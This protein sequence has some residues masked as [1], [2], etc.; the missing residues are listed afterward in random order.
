[1]HTGS[2]VTQDLLAAWASARSLSRGLP[3]AVIDGEAVRVDTALPSEE[4]R[5]I[6]AASTPTISALAATIDRPGILIKLCAPLPDLLALLPVGWRPHP[7]SFFMT[8]YG[9]MT[10]AIAPL[11]A[12]YVVT[13]A[14]D[15]PVLA[16]SVIAADGTLAARGRALH[17]AGLFVY[18]QIATVA[19][20]RRRGLGGHVMRSLQAA[21]DG[22][23]ARQVLTATAAGRTLYTSLG[24]QTVSLYS[25]AECNLV[26]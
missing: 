11:A 20:H 7:Q 18:D 2:Q 1:M 22:A 15:G 16:A 9:P 17:H 24:W 25:T 10:A 8:C 13:V 5:Y 19:D 3:K 26:S 21:G 6:F 23:T 12:G 4:R 14:E